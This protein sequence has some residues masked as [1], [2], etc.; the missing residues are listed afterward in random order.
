[1]RPVLLCFD[2]SDD[3]V[4]AIS[5]AAGLLGS[6]PAVILTVNEPL[7]LWEPTDP[8]TLLDVPIQKA[9]SKALELEEIVDKVAEEQM[10]R[11]VE[12][13]RAAGFDA[14]GRVARGKAWRTIC[15][16]A[17]EID[18]PAI[19]LGARGLSRV[20]SALLGSVSATVSAHTD[21]PVLIIHQ[22]HP[23]NPPVPAD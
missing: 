10:R 19:V 13:A 14:E 15:D 12:L 22:Q 3:A 7:R 20:Q 1:M 16:V 9:L 21:R 23:G 2:G 11:G 5:L 18:A 6:R 17:E 4:N 8:A